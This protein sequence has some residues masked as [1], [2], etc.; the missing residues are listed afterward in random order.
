MAVAAGNGDVE[1]AL[2]D[3]GQTQRQRMHPRHDSEWRR[4]SGKPFKKA[5]RAGDARLPARRLL[6]AD[7]GAVAGRALAGDRR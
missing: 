4:H 1:G 6:V 3:A 2:R 7:R 5:L